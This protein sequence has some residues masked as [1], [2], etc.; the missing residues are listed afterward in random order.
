MMLC[1]ELDKIV[2]NLYH[3]CCKYVQNKFTLMF[4][5]IKVSHLHLLKKFNTFDV[6]LVN[7]GYYLLTKI[8]TRLHH[9]C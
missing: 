6:L 8:K 2:M 1:P 9:Q 3:M 5:P 4:L 7:V